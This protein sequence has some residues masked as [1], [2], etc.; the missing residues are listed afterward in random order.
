MGLLITTDAARDESAVNRVGSVPVLSGRRELDGHAVG[1]RRR[2][3]Q[4]TMRSTI[5]K[6]LGRERLEDNN[7]VHAAQELYGIH[8]LDITRLVLLIGKT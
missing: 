1:N 2:A 8:L 5:T 3:A 7:L 6:L 4:E